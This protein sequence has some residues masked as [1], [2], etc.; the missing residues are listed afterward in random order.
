MTFDACSA[1]DGKI[2]EY[3]DDKW[4]EKICWRC[5]YYES[6]T[7]AFKVYPHL[8]YDI[9]RKNEQYYLKKYAY[10]DKRIA[11]NSQ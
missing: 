10:Y 6:D 2:Y 1:C 8:F 9:V 7:P 11:N 5:G 3:H 4:T